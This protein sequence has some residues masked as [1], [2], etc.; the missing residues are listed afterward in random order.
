MIIESKNQ[1]F[2]RPT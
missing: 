2:N 1:T